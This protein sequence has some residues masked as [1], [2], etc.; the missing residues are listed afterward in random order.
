MEINEI[1]DRFTRDVLSQWHKDIFAV[2]DRDDSLVVDWKSKAAYR[3]RA[4]R[5]DR[6]F[7]YRISHIRHAVNGKTVRSYFTPQFA[8]TAKVNRMLTATE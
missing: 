8:I 1:E 7:A 4:W 3:L 5:V 2:I 6:E